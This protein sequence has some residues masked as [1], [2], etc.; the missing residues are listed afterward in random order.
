MDRLQKRVKNTCTISNITEK[1]IY[2]LPKDIT[3]NGNKRLVKICN[4]Y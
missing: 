4:G 3:E 1:A 2:N